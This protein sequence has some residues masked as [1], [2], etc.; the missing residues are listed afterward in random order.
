MVNLAGRTLTQSLLFNRERTPVVSY[1]FIEEMIHNDLPRYKAIGVDGLAVG[2]LGQRLYNDYNTEYGAPRDEARNV[3]EKIL[4]SI[5]DT[6]GGVQGEKT[7]IYGLPHV[8][9][10]RGMVYDNSYDLFSDESVPFVQI[11]THGLVSYSSEYVNNRQEDVN[12]FLRDIEY[13]A[14]PAF[15]FTKAE[16]KTYVNS[17]G[18]RFYNTYYPDWENF[19]SEQYQR[20]NEALGDVQDQFITGHKTLA[21]GVKETTYANG[22]RIIVNYNLTPYRSGDL[23]VPEHNFTVVRGGGG[24]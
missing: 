6:L 21:P 19:A 1:K 17:Y 8:N 5:K 3:Q 13:G 4:S 14:V 11:A 12:D 2:M 9:Y 10:I 24:Q 22:K 16:T 7:N 18:L 23:V 15:V 20:Y